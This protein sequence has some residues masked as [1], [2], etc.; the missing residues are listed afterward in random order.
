MFYFMLANP[1]HLNLEHSILCLLVNKTNTIAG[2]LAR[3]AR[4]AVQGK[5]ELVL[6]VSLL[7]LVA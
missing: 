5:E 3:D 6:D 4:D 7:G 1:L 2:L